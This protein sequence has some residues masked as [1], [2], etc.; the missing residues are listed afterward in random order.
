MKTI[1]S[2]LLFALLILFTGQSQAATLVSGGSET[3]TISRPPSSITHTF[4]GTAGQGIFLFGIANDVGVLN[5]GVTRP[6][7]SS[8]GTSSNR[9]TGTLS[10]TGTYT[11]TLTLPAGGTPSSSPY[12][13]YYVKGGSTVS[14]GSLTSGQMTTNSLTT[15]QIK[16]YQFTGTS[17]EYMFLNGYS[18]GWLVGLSIYKPDGSLWQT[19]TSYLDGTLPATGTY[20]V[21]V[22]GQFYS[23]T[24]SYNLYYLKGASGV[25]NGVLEGQPDF[26]NLNP[27]EIR[28]WTFT[29]TPGKGLLV[30]TGTSFTTTVSVLKPDGSFHYWNNNG[31]AITLPVTSTSPYTLVVTASN[32]GNTGPVIL[33]SA[34]GG[35]SQV[36][37]GT[38]Q[39]GLTREDGNLPANG[40]DS[41]IFTGSS[42]NNLTISSTGAYTRKIHI[43]RPNGTLLGVQ[44]NSTSFTLDATGTYMLGL[45]GPNTVSSGPYTLTLTTPPIPPADST[46][47]KVET[48]EVPEETECIGCDCPDGDNSVVNNQNGAIAGGGQ[49]VP[50]VAGMMTPA[51]S[52]LNTGFNPSTS[53]GNPININTGYKQQTEVDYNTA[54]L[55]FA[56]IYRSDSSWT[57]NTVGTFWRHNYARTLSITGTTSYIIDGS[58]TKKTYT[59]SGSNWIPDDPSNTAKLETITGGYKY[60]L[61]NGTV[62]KYDSNKLLT[63][64]EYLGGGALNLTYNGSNELTGIINENGRSLSL[65]YSSGRVATLVTPDGTFSYSYTGS[66]LTTVTKPDTKTVIYHYENGTYPDAL[67]GI[68]DEKGNR[69]ATFTYGGSG[70]AS[71]TEHAGGV[72]KY[73]VA[74]NTNDSTVTNPLGKNT[75]YYYRNLQNVRRVT[76]IAAAA[77]TNCPASNRYFSYDNL[78]RVV[79]S[80]DWMGN[81]TRYAY[82][83]RSNLTQMAEAAGTGI[84]RM[85][86]ITWDNTFNLPNV[87]TEPGLTTDYDYDTYGRLTSMTQTDVLT[88]ATR[89]TTYT[90]H[91]NGTDGSGNTILGRLATV[92]GP[93]TDVSD[94]TSFAY[95]GSYNLTTVTN[96][97]SQVTT[98]TARDSAGRPT[99]VQDANGADLVVR[100]RG[101]F[102]LFFGHA[103]FITEPVPGRAHARKLQ[104]V[105]AQLR[106]HEGEERRRQFCRRLALVEGL[107]GRR[108]EVIPGQHLFGVLEIVVELFTGHGLA[109]HS[110]SDRV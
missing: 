41:Y 83:S 93:R 64:I 38:L 72:Q 74:Y 67:T 22:Y 56:R 6:D 101:R 48:I 52:G 53:I 94:I 32:F 108:A 46:N 25:S 47:D 76:Q 51:P 33:Y 106:Q 11:V 9:F 103:L 75:A 49:P 85:T 62:E 110:T 5:I 31:V 4:S 21:I 63:R 15:N 100:F 84:R 98:I 57:R 66:R 65:T 10:Q 102:Y 2:G 80:T 78:G 90:Y 77:S 58:G 16:S 79:F 23:S 3:G 87:V 20:T 96:A 99:T 30:R 50:N 26:T 19:N 37:N 88:G 35:T 61:H 105:G 44:D 28:S 68:T 104:R 59:L 27:G 24:G 36:S 12:T 107:S 70:K 7:G 45:Y 82:D 109:F 97:L 55:F 86:Y 43:M 81:V 40:L 95:D 13:L 14:D 42:G 54:G 18:T 71:A 69:F 34:V 92:D 91:S 73:Q 1:L 39:S 29:G 89:I 17:G 8:W 60:T